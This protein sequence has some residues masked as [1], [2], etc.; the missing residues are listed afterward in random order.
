MI[1]N[2][3]QYVP[4]LRWK[5]GE[6]Q[7]VSRLK[8]KTKERITPLI[9]IPEI[10]WD[11]EKKKEAKTIDTHLEPMARRIKQKWGKAPCFVDMKLI[12][13]KESERL[14][15]GVHPIKYLFD[16]LSD[17]E[18][19]AI[20]VTGLYRNKYYQQGLKNVLKINN[21]G[22]CL[23]ITIEQTAQSSFKNDL[24]S[25]LSE[26]RINPNESNFV[27][28]LGAPNFIPIDGF[29]KLIQTIISHIPYL[30]D[31]GTFSIIGTSF[32]ETMGGI[33]DGTIVL[34]RYEWQLYKNLIIRFLENEIRLPSFG[35]YC[36]SHPNVPRVDMRIV[37]PSATIR[38]TINDRWCILKN[39]NVRDPENANQYIEMSQT[40]INSQYY[41]GHDFS[42]G[43]NH[44]QMCATNKIP[45]NR[46]LTMWRQVGINHHI[47]KV[48][49]D[50]ANFYASSRPS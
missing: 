33:K 39:K 19:S 47:E 2:N 9:E 50:I 35:D 49:L 11:F 5:M 28:D 20:P 1:F 36:I 24:D 29:A 10:G 15:N 48:V 40:L 14:E 8:D 26:L 32:P 37:K 27:L 45:K 34:S 41:C 25:L 38:Y 31:W 30:N 21:L 4:C 18:C 12:F 17:L 22:I 3:K 43:D 6:Y 23:R 42:F 7:A 44:I 46:S 13:E 16:N